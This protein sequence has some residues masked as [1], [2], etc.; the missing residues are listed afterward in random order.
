M[1]NLLI[2]IIVGGI[3]GWVA[4]LITGTDK[5]MGWFSNVV[6]GMIG[7]LIGGAIVIFLNTG[8]FDLTNTAYNNFNLVSI[9]VSVL[10]AIVLLGIL[11]LLRR[12]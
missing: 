3:S 6:V 4:S 9:V 12:A 1:I 2:W 7:S 5:Q 10:G 8:N 11:K